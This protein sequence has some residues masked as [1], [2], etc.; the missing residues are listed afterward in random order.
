MDRRTH[1]SL[2]A[3]ALQHPPVVKTN[4]AFQLLIQSTN[5]SS[6]SNEPYSVVGNL[7]IFILPV[8]LF[9]QDR[10]QLHCPV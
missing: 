9:L 7:D 8:L 5:S 10:L 4:I 3:L 6:Q 2:V 1:Q